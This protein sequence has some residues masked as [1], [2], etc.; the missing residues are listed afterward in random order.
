METLQRKRL[1]GN[2]RSHRQR[3]RKRP[4]TALLVLRSTRCLEKWRLCSDA[5]KVAASSRVRLMTKVLRHHTTAGARPLGDLF[6]VRLGIFFF[7]F[8]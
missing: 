3:R 7:S 5:I 4:R 2:K 6:F 1:R 8:F